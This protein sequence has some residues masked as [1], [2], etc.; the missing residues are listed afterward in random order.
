[1][2]C[3]FHRQEYYI[4]FFITLRMT[5]RSVFTCVQTSPA[6]APLLWRQARPAEVALCYRFGELP[7]RATERPHYI[8]SIFLPSFMRDPSTASFL[9]HV[10]NKPLSSFVA[11]QFPA[12]WF[13]A[14][15]EQFLLLVIP[16]MKTVMVSENCSGH[17]VAEFMHINMCCWCWWCQLCYR[18]LLVRG[19]ILNCFHFRPWGQWGRCL[20]WSHVSFL[21]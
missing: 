21:M 4:G 2:F 1:V 20:S 17:D 14:R 5:A 16:E 9:C 6:G 10:Y 19:C 15:L 11:F 7:A 13:S 3:K 12:P 18:G 8:C